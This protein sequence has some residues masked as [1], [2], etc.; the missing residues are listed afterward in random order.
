MSNAKQVLVDARALIEQGWTIGVLEREINGRM[1]YCS[2]G[3]LREA[4]GSSGDDYHAA[5]DLLAGVLPAE[6]HG[7]T[8]SFNTIVFFN[9][10]WASSK[11]EVLAAFDAAI[12][13]AS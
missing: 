11:N 8:G 9:D 6:C 12:E 4:A 2:L 5:K 7:G 1:C 3:A 10:A 13:A